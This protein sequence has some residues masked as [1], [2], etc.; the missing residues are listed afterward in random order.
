M[1]NNSVSKYMFKSTFFI[2]GALLFLITSCT[3]F[4][5]VVSSS[6]DNTNVVTP[7]PDNPTNPTNPGN[8]VV[9]NPSLNTPPFL[10]E[11]INSLQSP[12]R[13]DLPGLGQELAANTYGFVLRQESSAALFPANDSAGTFGHDYSRVRAITLGN[14]HII[15]GGYRILRRVDSTLVRS[16][17]GGSLRPSNTNKDLIFH[18]CPS[19]SGNRNAFCVYSIT[20]DAVTILIAFPDF[21][22]DSMTIG[23]GEGSMSIDDRYIVVESN[24]HII[25]LM[26]SA[27][28]TSAQELGRLEKNNIH[29][30]S[31]VSINGTYVIVENNNG[32]RNT[33][34]WIRYDRNFENPVVI[35]EDG[36]VEH[37]ILALDDEGSEVIVSLTGTHLFSTRLSDQKTIQLG[38]TSSPDFN[39]GFGHISFA[40]NNPGFV[41][42]SR[43]NNTNNIIYKASLKALPGGQPVQF[44]GREVFPGEPVAW[45]VGSVWS[46]RNEYNSQPHPSVNA[47][48]DIIV[49]KSDWGGTLS[50]SVAFSYRLQK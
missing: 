1:I 26:L 46:S 28:L 32:D 11:K 9:P 18:M 7:S 34:E 33:R 35:A 17:A 21:S 48:G 36:F 41:F 5:G 27:D 30:W 47:E 12:A 25:S 15:V 8:P 45:A 14:E 38:V 37:S 42:L 31:S 22:S 13:P 20:T 43:Q 16:L 6:E 4:S 39:A 40:I 29:N 23:S 19:P 44:N 10:V 2:F 24:T 49:F 50:K 3:E